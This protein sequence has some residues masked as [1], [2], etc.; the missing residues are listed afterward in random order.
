MSA[1][2]KKPQRIPQT[3]CARAPNPADKNHPTNFVE[4]ALR[5]L[6]VLSVK[7]LCAPASLR[8]TFFCLADYPWLKAEIKQISSNKK[9]KMLA[10]TK[11]PH[12]TSGQ[13]VRKW[14][15][16]YNLSAEERTDESFG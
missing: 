13:P 3:T 16:G 1:E 2:P 11:P 4:P 8:E 7:L 5:V 6:R 14:E 9:R 15:F 12:G 10:W